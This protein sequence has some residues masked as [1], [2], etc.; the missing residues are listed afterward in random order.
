[1]SIPQATEIK[2]LLDQIL[3]HYRA[4]PGVELAIKLGVSEGYVRKARA[5]WRP[6]R[7]NA[8]LLQR[9]RKEAAPSAGGT[10]PIVPGDAV[11]FARGVLFMIE[12]SAQDIARNAADARLHLEW[13]EHP[14]TDK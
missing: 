11:G 8:D 14:P 6:K 12:R 10:G 4:W 13:S 2:R 1:M 3:D 9:L 5:G 7:V